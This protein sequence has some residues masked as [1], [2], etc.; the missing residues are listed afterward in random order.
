MNKKN[1]IVVLSTIMAAIGLTAIALPNIGSGLTIAT[2]TVDNARHAVTVSFDAS[3]FTAASGSIVKHG[4]TFDYS[5]ISVSGSTISVAVGGYL[6]SHESAN[7]I[8]GSGAHGLSYV[9]FAV[10]GT[11]VTITNS[12]TTTSGYGILSYGADSGATKD[13]TWYKLFTEYG[14]QRFDSQI[15]SLVAGATG[16]TVTNQDLNMLGDKDNGGSNNRWAEGSYFCIKAKDVAFTCTG[17]AAKWACFPDSTGTYVNLYST[18]QIG[19][20]DVT[21]A[22]GTVLP[23]CVNTSADFSFKV[24]PTTAYAHRVFT[25]SYSHQE[26]GTYSALTPTSGVYTIPQAALTDATFIKVAYST[27]DQIDTTIKQIWVQITDSNVNARIHFW[28][29]PSDWTTAD[30]VQT[31]LSS[32][33]TNLAANVLVGS[34][35]NVISQTLCFGGSAQGDNTAN[36]VAYGT[37]KDATAWQAVTFTVN[38]GAQFPAYAYVKGTTTTPTFYAPTETKTF[39]YSSTDGNGC[40]VF[41]AA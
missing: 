27:Y 14:S 6:V 24:T 17:M 25:V 13:K 26:K 15:T 3:D 10:Y 28:L 20:Y 23:Y 19:V 38:S 12:T 9:G 11:T 18:F 4:V 36:Y 41:T 22:D 33:N 31:N 16:V 30:I 40:L 8:A 2:E 7:T 1:K 29:D 21:A 5:G 39:T 35:A 32:L 37:N 34:T